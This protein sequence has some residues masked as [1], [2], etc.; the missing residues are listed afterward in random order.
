MRHLLFGFLIVATAVGCRT[1]RTAYYA[2]PACP[3]CSSFVP[4]PPPPEARLRPT[5]ETPPP[6]PAS[7]PQ[8]EEKPA[9]G[10]SVRLL[11]PRVK[12][13]PTRPPEGKEPPVAI[14][15]PDD[16]PLAIELPGFAMALPKAAS[17][18]QPFPEGID[19]LK[20]K[21]YKAA[22]HLKAPGEDTA[23]ARRLFEKRGLEYLQIEVSPGALNRAAFDAFVKAVEAEENLPIF[24]YDKDGSVSGG[25]WYLYFRLHKKESDDK[26]RAEAARLGLRTDDDGTHKDMWLAVQAFAASDK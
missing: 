1:Q 5:F 25:M 15:G 24:V 3:A 22:L 26:A 23:A 9:P 17:G 18:L 11:P 10:P 20:K 13:D 4:A 19:W 12:E 21:G 16:G 8:V 7:V 6:P 2:A 14:P